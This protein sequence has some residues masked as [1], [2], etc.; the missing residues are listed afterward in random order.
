MTYTIGH[1]ESPYCSPEICQKLNENLYPGA[2]KNIISMLTHGYRREKPQKLIS[3]TQNMKR[4]G[5][6]VEARS[7]EKTINEQLQSDMSREEIRHFV[8]TK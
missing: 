5:T 3:K 4:I 6:K 7:P 2:P 8:E 1:L